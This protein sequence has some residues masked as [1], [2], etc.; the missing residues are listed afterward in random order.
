MHISQNQE[1][2]KKK[3]RPH[4]LAFHYLKTAYSTVT[5]FAKFY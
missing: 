3:A 2:K 4:D 5:D 1:T